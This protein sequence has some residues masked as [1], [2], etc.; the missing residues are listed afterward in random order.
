MIKKDS[1]FLLLEHSLSITSLDIP[2]DI[3][4]DEWNDIYVELC[5]HSLEALP[6]KYLREYPI[7]D[8]NLKRVWGNRCH[9]II[10]NWTSVMHYQQELLE[11]LQNNEIECVIIKGAAAAL[12]YPI[13]Q[14]RTMGDVDFLVKRSDFEKTAELLERNGYS[15]VLKKNPKSHHYKYIKNGILFEL[16]KRLALVRE[17]QEALI[18]LFEEGIRNRKIEQL[19]KYEVPVLP[20]ELNGLV[21][22]LHIDQHLRSGIGLKQII[23]WM[24]YVNQ[25]GLDY[26]MPLIRT[27][28]MER[29]ALSVTAMCQQYFGLRASVSYAEEYPCNELMEYVLKK[30]NFG[31]KSGEKEKVSYIF[32][33]TDSPLQLLKRLQSG[34]TVRWKILRKY[35]W[36]QPFAWIYQIFSIINELA[37]NSIKWKDINLLQKEAMEQRELIDCLGL[38]LDMMKDVEEA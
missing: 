11:L 24:M 34:G 29:F 16:H 30:G 13:P 9:A 35:R 10:G 18:T 20:P 25:Y 2:L 36:L 23:D 3:Q 22:L 6:Y 37:D 21:L 19:G 31:I 5:N 32:M 26:A 14:L 33:V 8:E 7:S 1:L 28:G 27:L 38:N 12:S 4:D 17:S 15:L